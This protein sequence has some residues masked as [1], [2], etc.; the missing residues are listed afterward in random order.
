MR[1][2]TWAVVASL[3]KVLLALSTT[4]TNDA[5][6][7][8]HDLSTLKTEGVASLYREGVQYASPAGKLYQRQ[9][10]IHPPTCMARESSRMS[11]ACRSLSGC[12]CYARLR[13]LAQWRWSGYSFAATGTTGLIVLLALSPTS[14]R[15]SGFHVNTDPMMV[16]FLVLRG[17]WTMID[18]RNIT[19]TASLHQEDCQHPRMVRRINPKHCTSQG[20]DTATQT[21]AAIAAHLALAELSRKESALHSPGC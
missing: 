10:F 7:W 8:T 11:P 5:L 18:G 21:A 9:P 3:A 17:R 16:V 14:A 12:G 15:V 19:G 13:I 4:G 20:I 2:P 1:F 6:T